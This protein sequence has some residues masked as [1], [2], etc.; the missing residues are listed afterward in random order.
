MPSASTAADAVVC[1]PAVQLHMT[2]YIEQLISDMG[3]S[4]RHRVGGHA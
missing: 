2:D 1:A 3:L 4:T